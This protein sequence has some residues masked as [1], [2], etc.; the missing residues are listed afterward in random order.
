MC[1]KD[2]T[3]NNLQWLIYHTTK[4]NQSIS[5]SANIPAVDK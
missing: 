1:K 4:P 2:L 3:L 5:Y